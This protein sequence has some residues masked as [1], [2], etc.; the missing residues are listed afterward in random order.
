[1]TD[2]LLGYKLLRSANLSK[3]EEQI[4]KAIVTKLKCENIK[5]KLKQIY[6]N[7]IEISIKAGFELPF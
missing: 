5:S 1:M 3:K 6:L 2:N 7:G 4:I